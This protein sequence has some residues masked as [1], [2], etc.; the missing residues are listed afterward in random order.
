VNNLPIAVQSVAL[1]R[2]I[3]DRRVTLKRR[4]SKT[5][6]KAESQKRGMTVI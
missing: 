3:D 1:G 2:N 6:G 4:A 5:V